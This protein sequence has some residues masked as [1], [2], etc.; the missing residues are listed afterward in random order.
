MN[1]PSRSRTRAHRGTTSV[2]KS[3]T[4]KQGR[5]VTREE[6]S[7]TE[8]D[9]IDIGAI[10]NPAYVRVGGGITKNLGD[11]NSLRVDISV[12]LPCPPNEEAINTAYTSASSIVDTLISQELE[13]AEERS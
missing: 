2:S 13:N 1:R 4:Q 11:F 5:E 7:V 9:P 6:E 10:D 12:S 8:R 3:V